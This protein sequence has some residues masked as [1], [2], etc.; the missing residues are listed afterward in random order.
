MGVPTG[1]LVM[2]SLAQLKMRL[3][4]N[5]IIDTYSYQIKYW[6]RYADYVFAVLEPNMKSKVM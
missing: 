2:N 6:Y 4:E 1:L 5:N 3:F